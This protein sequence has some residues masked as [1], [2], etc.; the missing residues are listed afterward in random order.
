MTRGTPERPEDPTRPATDPSVPPGAGADPGARRHGRRRRATVRASFYAASAAIV[1]WAAFVV[2]LP[3]V[4]YLPATPT[5]IEPLVTLD[6]VAT[7]DLD[8]ETALLTVLLRQQPTVPSLG[9]LLDDRRSLRPVSAIYPA[10]IDR[11]EH[12]RAERERFERQFDIA[13]AVGAQAAGIEA[14]LVTEVV[15]VDVLP[16]SP[17]AGVLA[18][19]DTVVAIDGEPIVAAEELQ[20]LVRSREVGDTITL[21]VRHADE[22]R[23]VTVELA[24]FGGV[25]EPRLGVAIETAVDELRLPFE[26]TLDPEVRIGG[27]SAGLMVALTIY[28]LLSE[29][30]LLAGRTVVGTGTLDA[31]GRVGPVGGVP[32]KMLAAADHGADV[33]LVPAMQL[34]DAMTTAP[35]DLVVIGVSDLDEA[36][37]ALR[38]DPV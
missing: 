17:A 21:T 8:G 25:E 16:D 33:V 22:E 15:V 34:E 37:A 12:L 14:E 5:P 9:A 36:L 7:T 13:A 27:P 19:G 20:A 31:D 28:D 11:Q 3:F 2:P 6:G 35:D 4:E 18:R 26:V 30:D 23:E 24:A 29:E 1:A 32:E 38:R 10:G